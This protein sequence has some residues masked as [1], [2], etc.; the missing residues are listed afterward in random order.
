MV[1]DNPKILIIADGNY[2]KQVDSVNYTDVLSGNISNIAE[3]DIVIIDLVRITPYKAQAIMETPELRKDCFHNLLWA[4]HELILIT[5]G[6]Y[7]NIRTPKGDS[8]YNNI[9]YYLPININLTQ[10]YG[11]TVIVK[12]ETLKDY[13]ETHVGDQWNFYLKNPK[14][15]LEIDSPQ[16]IFSKS[17]REN[18]TFFCELDKTIAINGFKKPISFSVIYGYNRSIRQRTSHA[19]IHSYHT[20]THTENSGCITFLQPP[21]KSESVEAAIKTLL[22]NYGIHIDTKAPKWVSKIKVPREDDKDREIEQLITEKQSIEKDITKGKEEK[23]NL[24]RFKKLLYES[25]DELVHIVWDTLEEIGFKV[26]RYD[27]HKEDGCIKEGSTVAILEVKGKGKTAARSDLRELDDW[28]KEY[29]EHEGREPLGLFIINHRRFVEPSK[30][31]SPFPDDVKKYIKRSSSNISAMT[32]LQLFDIYC[33]VK[34]GRI[35]PK[36]IRKKI[37]ENRGIL[38]I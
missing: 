5:D 37:I 18:S 16:E 3:Y 13:H 14:E 2:P 15:D 6:R 30:R 12:D 29:L 25:D 20:V 9:L 35:K 19:T 22:T 31:D 21:N 26:N 38:K 36:D 8:H 7:K 28:I 10:E 4:N 27:E 23:K 32:S 1:E 24:T 34:D 11:N 17:E 33:K